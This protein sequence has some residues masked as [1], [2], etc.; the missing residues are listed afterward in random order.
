MITKR[1]KYLVYPLILMVT[2]IVAF[3]V[4]TKA[5]LNPKY[6]AGEVIDSLNHVKVYYN[7]GVGNIDGRNLTDDGYNLGLK[8]QCVEFVKRYYYK[9]L[10]HKMPDSYG[11]AKSFFNKNLDD[12][13]YNKQRG[14]YQYKNRGREKP[15]VND[16][17]VF[18]GTMVN[19]YGHVAIVSKVTEKQIEITQQNPG[20]RGRTREHISIKKINGQWIVGDAKVLGWLRK[21]TKD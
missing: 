4:L 3:R 10:N 11:H 14:L 21:E 19:R 17:M 7:G 12:G 18:D 13:E 9:H 16:L 15:K 1:I 6:G 2:V 8:Y 5:D 20:P